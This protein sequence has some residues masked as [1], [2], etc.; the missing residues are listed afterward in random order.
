MSVHWSIRVFC[1]KHQ[2]RVCCMY[3]YVRVRV[4]MLECIH[5]CAAGCGACASVRLRVTIILRPLK[6][7]AFATDPVPSS[8]V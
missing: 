1:N 5:A 6:S 7:S 3:A 4:Y 2:G 8:H